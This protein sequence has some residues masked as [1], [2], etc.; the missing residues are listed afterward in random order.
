MRFSCFSVLPCSAEVQVIW[1]GVVICPLIAY[2]I[3]NIS[4]KQISKS[5]TM[6]H[7]YSNPKVGRFWDTVYT[8]TKLIA[9]AVLTNSHVHVPLVDS[10]P[11]PPVDN[12]WAISNDDCPEDKNEDYLNCS[13]LCYARQLY[14]HAV[15]KNKSWFRGRF[16]FCEFIRV[17]VFCV[18]SVLAW[19]ILFSWCLLLFC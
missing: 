16:S 18:F 19:T 3:S 2:S 12:I 15:L 17:I 13:V 7:S 6:S 11:S 8:W 5:I 4:S 10:P 9:A 14:M 1:G